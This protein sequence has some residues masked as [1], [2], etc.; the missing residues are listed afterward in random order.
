MTDRLIDIRCSIC[1]KY[2][3]SVHNAEDIKADF[4]DSCK[5]IRET[6]IEYFI[7]KLQKKSTL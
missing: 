7:R 5:R 3:Y 4:C 1:K 6:P 2:L